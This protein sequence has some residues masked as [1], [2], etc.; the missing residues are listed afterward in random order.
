MIEILPGGHVIVETLS[1]LIVV[2]A[3]VV[4]FGLWQWKRH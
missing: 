1:V 4:C 2:G 3:F